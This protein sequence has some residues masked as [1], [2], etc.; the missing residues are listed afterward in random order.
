MHER[1]GVP[2]LD[3]YPLDTWLLPYI[4]FLLILQG[5]AHFYPTLSFLLSHPPS[6]Q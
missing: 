3:I 4:P 5:L 6:G 1:G 2:Q